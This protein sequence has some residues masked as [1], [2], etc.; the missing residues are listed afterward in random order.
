[1]KKLILSAAFVVLGSFAFAQQT[2]PTAKK[3]NFEAK[4]QERLAKMKTDL[5]LTD[6]QVVKIKELHEKKRAAKMDQMKEQRQE[7]KLKM[8]K[9]NEDMKQI[10]TPDQYT[11]W[12]EMKKQKMAEH[13]GMRKE[14]MEM[15]K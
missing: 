9:N 3:E 6:A 10:L 15:K 5:N 11:K 4:Q 2:T 7:M 1:M 8:E 14:K 13:K 12:Q